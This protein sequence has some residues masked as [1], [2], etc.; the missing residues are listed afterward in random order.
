[1]VKG[2]KEKSSS[3]GKFEIDWMGAN[4]RELVTST[5]RAGEVKQAVQTVY[6]NMRFL[7][8]LE[9]EPER[10]WRQCD[11]MQR[12]RIQ[13]AMQMLEREATI[14]ARNVMEAW[15]SVAF[16]E[17]ENNNEVFR[18]DA[19]GELLITVTREL[20]VRNKSKR[21]ITFIYI[22]MYGKSPVLTSYR[23]GVFG[24]L[25]LDKEPHA[26]K[27]HRE[28]NKLDEIKPIFAANDDLDSEII[29]TSL[30]LGIT[31]KVQN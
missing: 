14:L 7:R 15:G 29:T 30:A 21:G 6:D 18:I 9:T 11:G 3:F 17:G 8:C 19:Y 23:N 26:W 13:T 1:M 2:L 5:A 22:I 25:A 12:P 28:E 27:F 16:A 10:A 24:L 4:T 20:R 31:L